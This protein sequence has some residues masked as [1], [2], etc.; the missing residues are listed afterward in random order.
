MGLMQSAATAVKLLAGTVPPHKSSLL[1]HHSLPPPAYPPKL[2]S[3]SPLLTAVQLRS[4]AW[5]LQANVAYLGPERSVDPLSE[6]EPQLE[7]DATLFDFAQ[8]AGYRLP[9]LSRGQLDAH[10]DLRGALQLDRAERD[11]STYL[12]VCTHAQR[13]C[14]CG[15]TGGAVVAALRERAPPSLRVGE[16]AHVGGHKCVRFARPCAVLTRCCAGTRQTCLRSRPATGKR[17]RV[18]RALRNDINNSR[19]GDIL[20][21]HVDLLLRYV[22]DGCEALPRALVPHW[23]GG[24]GLAKEAQT[25]LAQQWL[26]SGP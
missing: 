13:D 18:S 12:L 2:A 8:R 4:A 21:E 22:E 16:L 11:T 17:A 25:E 3:F 20:P 19:F 5:E 6:Y 7:A 24:R 10:A 14:R 9:R 1:L 15:D 23:R 26:A